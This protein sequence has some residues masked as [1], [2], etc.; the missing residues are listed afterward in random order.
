MGTR[1]TWYE[2]EEALQAPLLGP[3]ELLQDN[4]V[5]HVSSFQVHVNLMGA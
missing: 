4:P 5:G 3:Q 2:V 1:W